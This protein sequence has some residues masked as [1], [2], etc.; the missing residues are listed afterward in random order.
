MVDEVREVSIYTVPSK[1]FETPSDYGQYY[2]KSLSF[3]AL[4]CL[5]ISRQ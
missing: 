2:N 5:F 1:S 3:C 4:N